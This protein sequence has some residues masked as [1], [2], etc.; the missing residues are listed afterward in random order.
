MAQFIINSRLHGE[1]VFHVCDSGGYVRLN[2]K[3]I[4]HGG[5]LLG[6]TVIA[7][8]VTLERI[9]RNWWASYLKSHREFL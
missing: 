6:S 7:N 3:Q 5:R 9:S 8:E 4:C 1:Q 2:G